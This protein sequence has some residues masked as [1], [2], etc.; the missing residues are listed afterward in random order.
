MDIKFDHDESSG[1]SAC[2]NGV[3][4][5]A[6][7]SVN[8]TDDLFRHVNGSWLNTH[9]IP[10]DRSADGSFH[11][12]QDNAEIRLREIVDENSKY[13]DDLP[14]ST[15][16]YASYM[17]IEIIEKQGFTPISSQLS[18]VDNINSIVSLEKV[19]VELL[20]S[21][22]IL[23][24]SFGVYSELEDPEIYGM[25]LGQGGLSLPDKAFYFDEQYESI[26][27]K[28]KEHVKNI[29]VLIGQQEANAATISECVFDL[30][31]RIASGHFDAAKCR[32][33]DLN[34]NLM[35]F[36]D[37]DRTVD[38]FKISTF[39]K[40]VNY[41]MLIDV[42]Q[43]DFF[44]NLGKLWVNDNIESFKYWL[45]YRIVIEFA[46]FLSENFEDEKFDFYSKTLGGLEKK[47]ARWKQ[48]VRLVNNLIGDEPGKIYVNL[49]FNPVAR[50]KMA[51]MVANL[52]EAYRC[53]I[54][55]S[56][57]MGGKTRDAAIEKL[58]KFVAK[59][60]FPR[61][62]HNYKGLNF[63]RTSI[64][65]NIK[66][67]NRY[68]L[69]KSF[70]DLGTQINKEEW[71][72]P[73]QTVNAYYSPTDNIIVFPAAIL[74]FPFFDPSRSDA[75]NYG[76]IGAVIGH[77]IG[78]GFDDQ[79]AKFDGDGKLRSWWEKEDE[80]E[81]K[82]L[83]NK[84]DE[85]FEQFVP[86]Q[87]IDSGEKNPPHVNGKLTTG[88]NVGDLCGVKIA[89]DAYAISRGFK[90]SI[91]LTKSDASSVQEFFI[92]YARIWRLKMRN[93]ELQTRL[94]TDPHSPAE[95]RANT[96]RNLDAFHLAFK[97]KSGDG[98]WL[99]PKERIKIW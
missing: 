15:A 59:I 17:D 72:M 2:G 40:K 49:Y 48:G 34:H 43:V 75:Q 28:F 12:L 37:L 63:T 41:E 99:Y 10:A 85:Q 94:T 25:H 89:L 29:F 55:N 39:F 9:E 61:S 91:E 69:N 62:W 16:L 65:E 71:Y 1:T 57:W 73:A 54:L 83:T 88:E 53:S 58:S 87:F 38:N 90:S 95:F 92:S 7:F 24:F 52:I 50:L 78:H 74:D 82:K 76:G 33:V 21:F 3:D 45:K 31:T 26:R 98:L 60:G 27:I 23:P 20:P 46:A 86:V 77:E 84:L 79:G 22:G 14:L 44:N 4:A 70:A 96:V 11:E 8:A 18:M 66:A 47:P 81:F 6:D 93:E 64:I 42:H 19:L 32:D 30:E 56:T 51:H 5:A 35:T 36:A 80:I 67:Y 68:T 13:A 97:S